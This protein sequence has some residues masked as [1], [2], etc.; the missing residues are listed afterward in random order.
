MYEVS[1]KYRQA[2]RGRSRKFEWRGTITTTTGRVYHFTTKDIVKGSGTLTRSCSGSTSLEMGSVYAAE[3]DISLFLNVDRYSLYD[4]VIDLFFVF[5]HRETRTWN[6][7]RSASWDSIRATAWNVQYTPEEI[8][9]GRFVISEAT[10]TLTV[11]QLKSYD[12]ML[13]FEKNMVTSGNTRPMPVSAVE[14]A[15]G[16]WPM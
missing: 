2:I 10:R 5:R 3:L 8:P 9:M 15:P 16:R 1:E 13:K 11:L 4:A 14:S 6:N 12:F 7:L